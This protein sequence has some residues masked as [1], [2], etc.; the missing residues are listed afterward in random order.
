M[1]VMDGYTATAIIRQTDKTLPIIAMTAN[2]MAGDRDKVIAAGM[3]DYISK[4]IEVAS[5]FATMAKWVKPKPSSVNTSD[6]VTPIAKKT[7]SVKKPQNQEPPK[8]FDFELIDAQRG[9][10]TANGNLKLYI[11]L[12]RKFFASQQQFETDYRQAWSLQ[13]M[14]DATRIAH[15]LKGNA[16]NIGAISLHQKAEKLENSSAADAP[17]EQLQ[18]QLEQVTELLAQVLQEIQT[19]LPQ[20]KKHQADEGTLSIQAFLAKGR[21]LRPF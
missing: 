11:K 18:T 4:P 3:N 12:L 14:A 8:E 6:S 16:G 5:M 21:Q 1:P 20:E 19:F 10:K 13:Q 7:D 15:T 17:T 2:A 9:L